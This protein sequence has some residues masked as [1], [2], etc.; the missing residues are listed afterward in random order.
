[1]KSSRG[2]NPTGQARDA[3]QSIL[4]PL[5]LLAVPARRAA[6]P[7]DWQAYREQ[8]SDVITTTADL[9]LADSAPLSLRPIHVTRPVTPAGAG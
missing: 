3:R 2:K 9:Q 6:R 8:R 7:S 5:P 1:M 4:T